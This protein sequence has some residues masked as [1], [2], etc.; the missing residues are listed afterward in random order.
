WPQT[1]WEYRH[2]LPALAARFR[3]FAVD[4]RGM[5]ASSKPESGY[6]KKTAAADILALAR[7]L[8]YSSIN[9]AGHDIGAMVAYSFA[10]NH[11]D[12]TRKV[13]LLE[14]PHPNKFLFTIA[15]LP[16]NPPP[17]QVWWFAFNQL[18]G[19]P[20]QLLT[21][22]FRAMIDW[23]FNSLMAHPEAATDRD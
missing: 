19:L 3:V 5:G 9:I 17:V 12:A 22:R 14:V 8:G 13:A 23:T 18:H 15:L 1:W 6:D 16:E 7:R 10:V 11:P 4:M 20:E 21:G 2:V